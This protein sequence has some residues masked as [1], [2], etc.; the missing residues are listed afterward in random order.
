MKYSLKI[1]LVILKFESKI[2]APNF[3]FLFQHC[4]VEFYNS[5]IL[6]VYSITPFL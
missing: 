3:R 4:R 6:R 5:R 1:Q 2:L